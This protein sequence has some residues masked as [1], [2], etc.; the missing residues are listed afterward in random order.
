MTLIRHS[1]LP[2]DDPRKDSNSYVIGAF[3]KTRWREGQNSDGDAALYSVLPKFKTFP[4]VDGLSS[5]HLYLNLNNTQN[6]KGLGFG[7]KNL[8]DCRL[9]LGEDMENGYVNTTDNCFQ[10]GY[11]IEPQ[12]KDLKVQY[13]EIWGL[14][15]SFD[16]TSKQQEARL[17]ATQ[18]KSK[19]QDDIKNT[20]LATPLP[21]VD[22]NIDNR[23]DSISND[24]TETIQRL[25]RIG[26]EMVSSYVDSAKPP[27][28]MTQVDYYPLMTTTES[29]PNTTIGQQST[30]NFVKRGSYT[31]SIIVTSSTSPFQNN[32]YSSTSAGLRKSWNTT[33][34]PNKN[35]NPFFPKNPLNSN[36]NRINT[37]S[38]IQRQTTDDSDINAL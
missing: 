29:E 23:I 1:N 33:P 11:L 14:G 36:G 34:D 10:E 37:N 16:L 22:V 38:I 9:W 24:V 32:N 26:T 13:I 19:F 35:T 27:T 15:Q 20:K 21:F 25:S 6:P 4:T 12:V 7:G 18:R 8:E 3:T 17:V 28:N 31:P 2:K 5:N 30:E